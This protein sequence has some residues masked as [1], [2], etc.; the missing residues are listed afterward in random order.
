MISRRALLAAGAACGTAF[1]TKARAQSFPDRPIRMVVPFSAGGPVDTMARLASQPL[2][3][4][5]GQ[6]VVIENRAGASGGIAAKP[7]ASAEPAGHTL[8]CG[9]IRSLVI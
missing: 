3:G 9:N 1:V 7:V 5:I 2:G 6:P 4:I 8:P